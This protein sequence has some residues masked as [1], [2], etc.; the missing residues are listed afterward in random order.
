MQFEY[1][2]E[3]KLDATTKILSQ[4]VSTEWFKTEHAY[5]GSLVHFHLRNHLLGVWTPPAEAEFQGYIDSGKLWLDENVKDILLVEDGNKTRMIDP[6][7]KYSGQMDLLC[8]LK[9]NP[10]P[11]VVDWK[12]SI[13]FSVVWAGQCAAYWNLARLNGFPDA[14]W[15]AAVRLRKS[16]KIALANFIP[17]L[18]LELQ[19]FLNAN[20]AFRRYKLKML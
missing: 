12:T 5:R 16:G 3:T 14:C 17:N 15:A 2:N 18:E 4:Y 11:G 9:I 1:V 8:T 13:S 10:A 19:Y 20:A 7:H 6:R